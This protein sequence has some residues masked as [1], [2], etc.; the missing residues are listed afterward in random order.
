MPLIS[1]SEAEAQIRVRDDDLIDV[2][3]PV[4]VSEEKPSFIKAFTAGFKQENVLYNMHRVQSETDTMRRALYDLPEEDF[5]VYDELGK[6]ENIIYRDFAESAGGI[7]NS[8]EFADWKERIG[9][10]LRQKEDMMSSGFSGMLGAMAGGV[11]D[12][13]VFIPGMVFLKGAKSLKT[14][15]TGLATGAGLGFG[16]IGAQ[17]AV[18]QATQ[19]TRS[20]GETAIGLAAGALVGGVL[21]GATVA[22]SKSQ[23]G[24]LQQ[25][26]AKAMKGEDINMTF[27][28]GSVGAA[29]VNLK[30]E[31]GIQGV[32][33]W[34]ARI[35]TFNNLTVQ[36]LTSPSGKVRQFT[37]A[38][39]EHPFRTGK[40]NVNKAENIAVESLLDVDTSRVMTVNQRAR[41][42]S[43]KYL[44]ENKRVDGRLS[45]DEFN[46]E[47]A[48]AM[49]KDDVH[50]I[51]AV[52]N[53]AKTYRK[54]VDRTWK[55]M[56]ELGIVGKEEAAF[57]ANKS[58]FMQTWN[59]DAIIE[60]RR[61]FEKYLANKFEDPFRS[62]DKFDDISEVMARSPETEAVGATVDTILGLGDDALSSNQFLMRSFSPKSTKARKIDVPQE[63]AIG[64]GWMQADAEASFNSFMHKSNVAI[65]MKEWLNSVDAENLG[66]FKQAIRDDM[67]AKGLKSKDIVK[68]ERYVD[69]ITD[70]LFGTYGRTG[71]QGLD[72]SLRS[73][74]KFNVIAM[75][76]GVAISS[77]PDVAGHILVNGLGRTIRDSVMPMARNLEAAKLARHEMQDLVVATKVL[78]NDI[79]RRVGETGEP[80][81]RKRTKIERFGDAGITTFGRLTGMDYWNAAHRSMAATTSE[82]RTIRAVMN[83]FKHKQTLSVREE[84]RLRDLGIGPE[85]Q[86]QIFNQFKQYGEELDGSF[87]ANFD[88]WSD[89]SVADKFAA[90]V[91][92]EV[93]NVI[94]KPG[95]GDLPAWAQTEIGK[96]IAQFKSF[97]FTAA[98]RLVLRGIQRHDAQTFMHL[99]T[100]ISL[101]SFTG[102]LK[103]KIEG[104]SIRKGILALIAE[105]V[106]RS[107][108][109]GILG[110]TWFG[111]NP[112]TR[113][114]RFAGMKFGNFVFGPS[115]SVAQNMYATAARMATGDFGDSTIKKLRRLI[116]FNNLFYLR[117]TVN[118][119][120]DDN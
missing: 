90:T 50:E 70:L 45:S 32:N 91:N 58:W 93:N 76:G 12:P 19:E 25:I 117:A 17:E 67:T 52:S 22:L 46:R 74:R 43:A 28:K 72:T 8:I 10:Q 55:R 35:T 98:N 86:Q 110:E 101:G 14:I 69:T 102:I 60:N 16:A 96:T 95:K 112:W 82:A 2:P 27:E 39:L 116:P 57:T 71:L 100:A 31:E 21:G 103:N 53:V 99:F 65:R 51:A 120:G 26:A 3:E 24:G 15:S 38:V 36:G 37:N 33:D 115:A 4:R 83:K 109:S 113:S 97:I 92:K 114:T 63:E 66:Q 29:E 81:G 94:L 56:Q 49:G 34:V 75:L 68:A 11:L 108:V 89:V 78:N 40:A 118:A 64:L 73:L 62:P 42:I 104:R 87:I 20:V 105:G 18:L 48:I 41:D 13:T 107:G 47:V 80:V 1:Q 111:L 7:R 79:L 9:T 44:K 59:R 119:F 88:R 61:E 85:L 54:E 84:Q 23:V 30:V 106:S 6:D 5:D 77:I